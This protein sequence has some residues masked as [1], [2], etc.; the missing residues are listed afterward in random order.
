MIVTTAA[1]CTVGRA[2][3]YLLHCI[4]Q[5]QHYFHTPFYSMSKYFV[6]LQRLIIQHF[7]LHT[8][9][10]VYKTFNSPN[11][12][13]YSVDPPIPN[14]IEICSVSNSVCVKHA[15]RGINSIFSTSVHLINFLQRAHADVFCTCHEGL[16]GCGDIAPHIVIFM[17]LLVY[18]RYPLNRS[19]MD[20][21]AGLDTLQKRKIPCREPYQKPSVAQP[22][23]Q[24]VYCQ[25]FPG[26]LLRAHKFFLT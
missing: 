14:F 13:Q 22:V 9:I 7:I 19:F 25:S 11:G 17:P 12:F 4:T 5:K 15:D 1:N 3:R 24:S 6:K 16:W 21:T 20:P 23:N 18:S 2:N 10:P 8:H 26:F